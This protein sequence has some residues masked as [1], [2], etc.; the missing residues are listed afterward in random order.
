MLHDVA[1]TENGYTISRC[2]NQVASHEIVYDMAVDPL[3]EHIV[4]VGKVKWH[5]ILSIWFD[6]RIS[7]KI[8]SL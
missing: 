3:L 7:T 1:A 5:I 8:A 6:C 4:T 2:Q